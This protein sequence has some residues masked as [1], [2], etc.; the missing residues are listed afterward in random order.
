MEASQIKKKPLPNNWRAVHPTTYVE[1]Q[2][3][4]SDDGKWLTIPVKVRDIELHLLKNPKTHK[5]E[6]KLVAYFEG[7]QKG[8]ILNVTLNKVLNELTGSRDPH[9]WVGV[10]LELYIEKDAS[11]PQGKKD[12]VRFRPS[13]APTVAAPV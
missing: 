3:L 6:E 11:T 9:D 5:D 12:V 1:V 10:Y 2:D 4:I 8:M 13:K 7:K